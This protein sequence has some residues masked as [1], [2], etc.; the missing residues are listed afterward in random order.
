MIFSDLREKVGLLVFYEPSSSHGE[1][2]PF[3]HFY[4]I[5]ET[6][7]FLGEILC[8]I[9]LSFPLSSEHPSILENELIQSLQQNEPS[10][11]RE[12]GFNLDM[13]PL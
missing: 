13:L 9:T 7:S 12:L 8:F 6:H 1:S 4:Q 5:K 11:P 10:K 2:I 3:F